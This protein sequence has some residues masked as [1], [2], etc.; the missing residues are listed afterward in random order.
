MEQVKNA[1][2][3]WGWDSHVSL[4]LSF[5]DPVAFSTSMVFLFSCSNYMSCE[6]FYNDGKTLTSVGSYRCWSPFIWSTSTVVSDQRQHKLA[7]LLFWT[8]SVQQW[9]FWVKV[10]EGSYSPGQGWTPRQLVPFCIYVKQWNTCSC[11]LG[12]RFVRHQC[13]GVFYLEG[14]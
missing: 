12:S 1:L 13:R 6:K 9:V 14:G 11:P 7:E 2:S 5:A 3:S 4:V 8:I 10:W